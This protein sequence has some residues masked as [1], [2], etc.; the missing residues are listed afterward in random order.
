MKDTKILITGATGTT[1]RPAVEALLQKGLE[2]RAMVHKQDH[3]SD[4][5]KELGAEIMVGDLQNL[6]AGFFRGR[7]NPCKHVSEAGS[8][9]V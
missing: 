3:R 5:L 2:V 4:H 6:D 8:L 7:R 9:N 1:G